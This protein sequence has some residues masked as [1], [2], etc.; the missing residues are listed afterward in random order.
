MKVSLVKNL[1]GY[2]ALDVY[3]FFGENCIEILSV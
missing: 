2:D 3:T 1:I